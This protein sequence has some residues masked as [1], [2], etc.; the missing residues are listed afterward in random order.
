VVGADQALAA[1]LTP[2]GIDWRM[3]TLL[4]AGPSGM[5]SQDSV[6]GVDAALVANHAVAITGRPSTL[7][8]LRLAGDQASAEPDAGFVV[9][10]QIA[11]LGGVIDSF[12]GDHFA[13][14]AARQLLAVVWL[15]KHSLRAGEPAGGY[16][17]FRCP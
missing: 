8:L 5:I 1:M 13:V 16:A 7:D 12:E 6:V 15:T 10:S 14:A 17:L 3:R 11:G 4:G 9:S 2:S